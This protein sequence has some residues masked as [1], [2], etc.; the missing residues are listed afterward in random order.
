[1]K[2]PPFLTQ[3]LAHF[4]GKSD[5]S[6][7][8]MMCG[9]ALDRPRDDEPAQEATAPDD[10]A[11]VERGE[12]VDEP[13]EHVVVVVPLDGA[14][15]YLGIHPSCTPHAMGFAEKK[16]SMTKARCRHCGQT[17]M[18]WQQGA[19]GAMLLANHGTDGRCWQGDGSGKVLSTY[20][21]PDDA[22]LAAMPF[23]AQARWRELLKGAA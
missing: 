19:R 17:Y 5:T 18:R 14:S 12:F 7:I 20:F 10:D 1:M 23:D 15:L 9:N 6:P 2:A 3:A 13:A 4:F 8:C 22:T 11:A 16:R 21:A